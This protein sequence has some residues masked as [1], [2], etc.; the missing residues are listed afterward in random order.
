MPPTVCSV[1]ASIVRLSSPREVELERREIA[2]INCSSSIDDD[3]RC[4]R[5]DVVA[6]RSADDRQSISTRAGKSETADGQWIAVRE[7]NRQLI[8]RLS[9]ERPL[10]EAGETG[11]IGGRIGL[12]VHENVDFGRIGAVGNDAVGIVRGQ[13]L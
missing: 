2:V 4:R 11:R 6:R 12:I 5:S 1:A 10:R 7:I 3:L 13:A 8:G 9:V